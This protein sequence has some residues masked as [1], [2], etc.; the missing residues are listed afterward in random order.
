MSVGSCNW[1]VLIRDHKGLLH[2]KC[3]LKAELSLEPGGRASRAS[4]GRYGSRGYFIALDVLLE[5]EVIATQHLCCKEN[6]RIATQ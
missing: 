5:S 4:F 1:L 2:A 3:L 6:M